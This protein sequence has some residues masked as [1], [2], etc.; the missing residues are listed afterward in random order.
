MGL[1][2]EDPAGR[3]VQEIEPAP[4]R[5]VD[6][7]PAW[8]SAIMDGLTAAAMEPEGTSYP[9]FGEPGFPI[10]VAGKTGTAET[11]QPEDQSWYVALAPADD[12]EVV[13]AFTFE[14]GGFGA[15][16]AAPATRALLTEYA[17]KYL[18]VNQRQFE[19]SAA[20]TPDQTGTVVFE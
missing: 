8:Q 18:S 19:N 20:E 10:D 7:D 3:T 2:A 4:S 13:V 14:N 17:Q 12:P 16:T 15:D 1:R 9:V 11:S 5:H 6:I